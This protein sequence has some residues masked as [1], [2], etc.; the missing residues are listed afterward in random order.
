MAGILI[1]AGARMGEHH[2]DMRR[3]FIRHK[4]L[5]PTHDEG[6]DQVLLSK[7]FRESAIDFNF[8]T[9]EK[10]SVWVMGTLIYGNRAGRI[11]LEDLWQDLHERPLE[12]LMQN[13]DGP[14]FLALRDHRDNSLALAT[15]HAG[16]VNIYVFRSGQNWAIS[17][18]SMALS[19]HFPVTPDPDNVAQ[20]LRTANVYGSGTIY[21][22]ITLLEPACIYRITGPEGALA[23]SGRPYWRSP[24]E[25]RKDLSFDRARDLLAESL[26]ESTAPLSQENM[27]C[28]F[29]AGFDS[30][31]LVAAFSRRRPF[32]ELPTFVFGPKGSREVG[33]VKGYCA[34][35]GLP[36]LHLE[37]PEEWPDILPDYFNQ[38]LQVTD[39]EENLMVYAPIL[40]AQEHKAGEC[41]C[42]ING[43]G[44]ELYRDFWWIQELYGS[45]RP[46]N[47]ERLISM[48]MLQYEFDHFVFSEPWRQRMQGVKDTLKAVFLDTLADMDLHGSYNTLQIDN[49][50]LRQKIRRWAGRTMSSSSRIVSALAPLTLKR[51]LDLVL[52]VPPGYKK[53]GR[54]VKSVIAQLCE[55]LSG[56]RMLNGAPCRNITVGNAHTFLPLL[57]DYARRGMRKAVQKALNRTILLDASVSYQQSWFF[58]CLF[59]HP[60]MQKEFAY[61]A[62]LTQ[63]MYDPAR[64]SRFHEEAGNGSF[65]YCSQLGNIM[66]LEMRMRSDNIRPHFSFQEIMDANPAAGERA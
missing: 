15:D 2:E 44:G 20:F 9:H 58:S 43:L 27:V 50:Y 21:Q 45:K 47:I 17:S 19:T 4:G 57:A 51:N 36:N 22:E 18:S 10:I 62:L 8:I 65:A 64:Y 46:A 60:E 30:R 55:P 40:L 54:L 52:A 6:W 1:T 3:Y 61:P 31:L 29:T 12:S 26:V 49:L 42:S 16:I 24:V 41:S 13:C 14:F 56:L 32:S 28:D 59:S 35:L 53:G 5:Q 11:A 34:S 33:L 66:T 48:R 63:G 7:F 37:L 39:G 25:I 38:S 23:L